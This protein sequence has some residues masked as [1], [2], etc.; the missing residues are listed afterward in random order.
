MFDNEFNKDEKSKIMEGIGDA[1]VVNSSITKDELVDFLKHKHK[2]N[3]YAY[4]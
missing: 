1:L 3:K 4:V 2:E